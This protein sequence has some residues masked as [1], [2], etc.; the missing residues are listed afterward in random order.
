MNRT[1]APA[2]VFCDSRT[3]FSDIYTGRH[4]GG[5]GNLHRTRAM[6]HVRKDTQTG[7]GTPNYPRSPCTEG[8]TRVSTPPTN[9]AV[10][11]PDTRRGWSGPR[12]APGVLF[13]RAYNTMSGRAGTARVP[14]TSFPRKRESR[15]RTPANKRLGEAE[16]PLADATSTQCTRGWIPAFAGMTK[17][18]RL[19]IVGR[20][21]IL[22]EALRHA[23]TSFEPGSSSFSVGQTL[24]SAHQMRGAS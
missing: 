24:L 17:G 15:M 2:G 20:L 5:S 3:G 12:P 7:E 13:L 11:R 18:C 8:R 14:P 22:L 16:C 6:R 9:P 19:V 23:P 4:L 10:A 21:F 1:P